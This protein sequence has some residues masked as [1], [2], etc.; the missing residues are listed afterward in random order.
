MKEIELNKQLPVI[1]MNFEE[2]KTSL[3]ETM[4]KYKGIIVTEEGLK[5]CKATQKELA[6]VRNKIDTYRKEVKKEMTKPISEF[7]DKCK[8]LIKLVE[9]AE[10]PIKEGI[11]IFDNKKREEKRT[12]ALELIQEAIQA[13]GLTEKY[14]RQLV[15]VDRYMN[16]TAKPSEVKNDIEQKAMILK[17]EQ[18]KELED[19]EIV[20]TTIDSVNTTI[21]RKLLFDEFEKYIGHFSL[22]EIISKINKTAEIIREAENPKPI[23]PPKEEVKEEIKEPVKEVVSFPVDF[24]PE[25]I[26]FVNIRV[27]ANKQNIARLSSFLKAN[28]YDY[29]TIDK[30]LVR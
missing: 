1:T 29:L 24:S 11:V 14:A 15:V 6:G 8:E 12:K 19:R 21:N 3:T 5:D 17:K 13:H 22:T 18:D 30:G 27:E 20:Q 10:Q 23:E 25:K 16:L 26:Y 28:G 7:E 4:D 2:V 9:A